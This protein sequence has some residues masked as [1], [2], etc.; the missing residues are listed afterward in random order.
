MAVSLPFVSILQCIISGNQTGECSA[1]TNS[2]LVVSVAA[3][4]SSS[5]SP[6]TTLNLNV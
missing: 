6:P 4:L 5:Q 1:K 2:F 3:R